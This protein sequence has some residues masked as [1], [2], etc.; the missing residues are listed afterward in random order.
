M[1]RCLQIKNLCF[2]NCSN[3]FSMLENSPTR[4]FSKTQLRLL[5]NSNF[6]NLSFNSKLQD[7][8]GQEAKIA[9]D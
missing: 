2:V 8:V 5:K 6:I 9:Y 4:N 3:M 1:Y 7:F